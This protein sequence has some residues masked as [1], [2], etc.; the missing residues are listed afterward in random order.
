MRRVALITGAAQGIGYEAVKV[1]AEDGWEVHA[2]DKQTG[3]QFPE[4]VEFTQADVSKEE[5]VNGLI[6]EMSGNADR[7]D[8][9]VNNAAVQ[10]NAPLIEMTVDEWDAVMAT[11]LRS[12]FLLSRHAHHLLQKLQGSIVNVSSVHA[13]ATSSS[14]AAYA[15]SKGAVLALTRALALEFAD[16]NIR[17]N[18]MLPGAVNTEMLREGLSRGHLSAGSEADRLHEL[19]RRIPLGRVAD[20]EEIAQGILFL[21]DSEKSGYMTGQSLIMDGGVLARLS[22]E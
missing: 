1:F 5:E 3:G 16:D 2:V 22:S 18:A 6:A 20:P 13:L 15:A 9:L 11:N 12:I 14:V 10:I 21:A 17:V 19:A 7:L 4:G 8:A